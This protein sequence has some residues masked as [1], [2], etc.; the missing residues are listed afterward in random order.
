MCGPV[1]DSLKFSNFYQFVIYV[2][3]LSRYAEGK[4]SSVNTRLTRSGHG[5]SVRQHDLPSHNRPKASIVNKSTSDLTLPMDDIDLLISGFNKP[6]GTASKAKGGVPLKKPDIP[7]R[8]ASASSP[9]L[10]I[11]DL[12]KGI[13]PPMTRVD[14]IDLLINGLGI[15]SSIISQSM[16]NLIEKEQPQ[17]NANLKDRTASNKNEGPSWKPIAVD[18]LASVEKPI[19]AK[20]IPDQ[21]RKEESQGKAE[22]TENSFAATHQEV[23][24]KL[25]LYQSANS[26]E[27]NDDKTKSEVAVKSR[28]PSISLQPTKGFSAGDVLA[29]EVALLECC[30]QAIGLDGSLKTEGQMP[31]EGDYIVAVKLL[32]CRSTQTIFVRPIIYESKFEDMNIELQK[33]YRTS[34][35]G[36]MAHV[37]VGN[38]CAAFVYG[39]WIRA[40]ITDIDADLR[41]SIASIDCGQP[42]VI[43]FDQIY[44]LISPFD[45]IPK[46]A[47]KCSL[48]GVKPDNGS[49]ND[50]ITAKITNALLQA[51]DVYVFC[52]H[53][54]KAIPSLLEVNIIYR[55]ETVNGVVL[56]NLKDWLVV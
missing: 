29:A 44:S 14:D 34:K 23:S 43:P 16:P 4:D 40:V 37:E 38:R 24:W 49:P 33:A 12:I 21:S 48:L 13:R 17:E 53:R 36:K 8:P 26:T 15:R 19:A 20:S 51:D 45:S 28:K 11:D 32:M 56:T 52:S 30:Y 2:L 27:P 22:M 47:L 39:Q 50:E 41:C 31:R 25:P 42:H 10:D 18:V 1:C 9:G 54:P 3:I 5:I 46:F 6:D 35:V 7:M 55:H